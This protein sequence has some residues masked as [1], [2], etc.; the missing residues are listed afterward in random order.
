MGTLPDSA[1]RGNTQSDPDLVAGF[2]RFHDEAAGLIDVRI[3]RT[4]QFPFLTLLAELGEPVPMA[5]VTALKMLRRRIK[6]LEKPL[7]ASC[8]F[9]FYPKRPPAGVLILLPATDAVSQLIA[10]GICP[11]CA[12]KTDAEIVEGFA[13]FAK[14]KLWPDLRVIDAV[15]VARDGGRA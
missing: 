4:D 12:E 10:A 6:R 13:R 7:C 8:D 3:A 14:M 9:T 15:H 1:A 11:G 5:F 2:E